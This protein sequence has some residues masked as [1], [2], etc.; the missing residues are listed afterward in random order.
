M[1][2]LSWKVRG[3]LLG[4]HGNKALKQNGGQDNYFY[5]HNIF[6]SG[7]SRMAYYCN[8]VLSLILHKFT[9]HDTQ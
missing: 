4:Y 1:T 8:S 3:A 6:G 7:A 5:F 2:E 9:V